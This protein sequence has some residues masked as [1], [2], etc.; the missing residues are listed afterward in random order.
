M[1]LVFGTFE[2][3]Q[4][5]NRKL[6]RIMQN[7]FNR[8]LELGVYNAY[9]KIKKIYTKL[10]EKSVEDNNTKVEDKIKE[11]NTYTSKTEDTIEI[12]RERLAKKQVNIK[13]RIVLACRKVFIR[14][15]SNRFLNYFNR[16][17]NKLAYEKRVQKFV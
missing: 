16:W 14:N 11:A 13:S 15:S 12:L 17:R 1:L 9:N 8:N 7:V 3:V 4:I 5:R 10:I 2:N 6:K